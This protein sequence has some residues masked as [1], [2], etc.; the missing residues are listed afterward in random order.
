MTPAPT[1][2]ITELLVAWN[3]GDQLALEQL[4]PLV[5]RELYGLARGYL[6][7]ERGGH[8]LQTTALVNEAFVRLIEWQQVVWHDRAHFFGVSATLMRHILVQHARERHAQK[9]GGQAVK[10]SL[11][12]AAAVG[13]KQSPDLVALDDALNTLARLDARQ[14]R[15]VELRYFGGLSLEETA[16]VLR[17]SLSTVRR[18]WRIARAWLHHELSVT[19]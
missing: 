2:N 17:V 14:A 12:A 6:A 10:V 7:G 4:T 16:E 3:H 1:S 9:R 8:L 19:R 13:V 15:T 11:S 5:Y 18:D